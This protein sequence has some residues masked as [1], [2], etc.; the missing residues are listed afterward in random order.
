MSKANGGFM[1]QTASGKY[2]SSP[3]SQKKPAAKTNKKA[4]KPTLKYK[5]FED[6]AELTD[7]PYWKNIFINAAYD[8]FPRGFM[9]KDDMIIYRK[10]KSV[11]NTSINK[12]GM[13]LMHSVIKFMK[14]MTGIESNMEKEKQKELINERLANDKNFAE[15]K[16][17]DIKRKLVKDLLIS[18]Y[19]NKVSWQR[20]LAEK[21]RSE[22][23]NLVKI[24]FLIGQL[25]N[26]DVIFEGGQVTG[27][28]GL[29]FENMKLTNKVKIK[30][31]KIPIRELDLFKKI[32]YTKSIS[33]S[34]EWKILVELYIGGKR[35]AAVRSTGSETETC[36]TQDS[37]S[38]SLDN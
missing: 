25:N 11:N 18:E 32:Q 29:D 30:T 9:I 34:K 38:V 13:D 36:E 17:S 15:Y 5:I 26:N 3:W 2:S 7:D 21:D 28:N 8:K 23:F 27:I 14:E 24:G 1:V 6:C 16:W 19:L 33:L 4:Q 10:G 37:E 20:E 35:R 12:N 22:L 31:K